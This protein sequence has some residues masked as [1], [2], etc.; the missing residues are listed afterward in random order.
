MW[1]VHLH[2]QGSFLSHMLLGRSRVTLCSIEIRLKSE[3]GPAFHNNT[4]YSLQRRPFGPCREPRDQYQYQYQV[5]CWCTLRHL[6]HACRIH[7]CPHGATQKL[8]VWHRAQT[9]QTEYRFGRH[10]LTAR[11]LSPSIYRGK[12]MPEKYN[13]SKFAKNQ[14]QKSGWI[15]G[16]GLGRKEDGISEALKVKI[17]ADNAGVGHDP[18]EQFT[19][20]WWDHAFRK[21]AQN[22]T[23][24]RPILI[25]RSTVIY[26]IMVQPM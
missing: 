18:A 3:S 1:K 6:P 15:E 5:S 26:V 25:S 8:F 7:I 2:A 17:K 13:I 4:T 21:S 20:H 14:L 19:F 16:K 22:I 23:V 9:K 11:Q 24:S 12:I 10:A